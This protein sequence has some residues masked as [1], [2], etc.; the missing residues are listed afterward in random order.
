MPY[1]RQESRKRVDVTPFDL[2]MNPG[3]MNYKLSKELFNRWKLDPS[4]QT[5]HDLTKEWFD[6]DDETTA[7]FLAWMEFMRRVVGSFEDQKIIENGDIYK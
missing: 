5:I 2:L 7:R 3:E 1:I 4:Y 6:F